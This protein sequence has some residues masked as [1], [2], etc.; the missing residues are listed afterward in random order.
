VG[1]LEGLH[2][3]K[4]GL[5]SQFRDAI[6]SE[7]KNIAR[8]EC[9]LDRGFYGLQIS[10]SD[11]QYPILQWLRGTF[12]DEP[13]NGLHSFYG[14]GN[15]CRRYL[16]YNISV[17]LWQRAPTSPILQQLCYMLVIELCQQKSWIE[18]KKMI[19]RYTL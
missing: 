13:A 14:I 8:E 16:L 1:A 11:E 5:K 6:S 7:L 2:L 10:C 17:G 15:G 12:Y 9:M 18:R 4:R 3:H 19:Q